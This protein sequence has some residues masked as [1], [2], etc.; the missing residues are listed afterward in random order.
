MYIT[1]KK[2]MATA[3]ALAN[4]NGTDYYTLMQNAG[5][6]AA[7]YIKSKASV[8]G[9]RVLC[10][11][12]KG[13]NGGDGFVIASELSMAGAYVTVLLT[14]GRPTTECAAKAYGALPTEVDVLDMLCDVQKLNRSNF[15]AVVD[16]VFG[17]G[18]SGKVSD[19]ALLNLF[20]KIAFSDFAVDVPSGVACDDGS[21]FEFALPAKNTLTFAA[22]KLCHVLPNSADICGEVTVLDIG[23][24]NN[25][26][27][28]AGAYI[29]EIEKPLQSVRKKTSCKSDYGVLLSVCGSYGMPGAALISAKAAL[30]SGVGI[31]KLACVEQNYLACAVS[32]PEAVLVPCASNG[33]TYA[34]S[35][36]SSLKEQLDKA[37]ALLIGCGMGVSPDTEKL[38][39]EL[40]LYSKVP[41]VLDADGINVIASDIELLKKVKAP[42]VL[43][44]H[45]GEMSR[46]C[47]VTVSDIEGLRFKYATDFAREYGVYLL[48]KGANTILAE[49][50]GGL[51]VNVI[52]NAGMAVAGSGDM[53]AGIIA[54]L[55]AR[56]GDIGNAVKAAVW[57]HSAA[58]DA[59]KA[60]I[61]ETAMLPSDM[62]DELKSIV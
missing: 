1:D 27:H 50:D 54:A 7:M 47:G 18:Y 31:L 25:V 16:A 8:A 41:T 62:I 28:E 30:R 55:A 61:G 11:C 57:Y 48:L 14:H 33:K 45:P 6:S 35:A 42:L 5:R 44:P 56:G 4:Q 51:S 60:G 43:T 13:N 46:L 22:R 49:P 29:T 21:G 26:L 10:L 32:V 24:S 40:L 23:I 15:D 37:D 9:K 34:D 39:K 58:G 2:T 20:E 3:E 19:E 36:I 12:G 59:A 53:L 52:G 17:T 38:V